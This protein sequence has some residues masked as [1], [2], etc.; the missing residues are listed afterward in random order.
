MNL[1]IYNDILIQITIFLNKYYINYDF[2]NNNNDI[3]DKII[4]ENLIKH[5][6][7][8]LLYLIFT[9]NF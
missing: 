8:L 3:N 9:D 6:Y 7:Y 2:Y 1:D 5:C 4:L